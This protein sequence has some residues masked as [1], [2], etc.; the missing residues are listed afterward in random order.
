MGQVYQAT[1]TK[2]KRQVALKILP[3][4]FSADPERLARFQ[5]EAEV[6]ASLNHPNIAAIHGLEEAGDTR[7]LVLELVEGPTLADRIKQGPIPLDEALPIAK[8]IAEALE[9]AHEKGII[10]RDL[11][12]ANIKV[13]D[14]GTVKV[15]D[16]GLAKALDPSP[17]GDQSQSPTLTAM[18]TQMGVIMGTA[19]YM[20]PEQARGKTVDKRADIWAFGCVLYEMLTGR[21]AFDG[22]G[23]SEVLA[24]VIRDE[25]SLERIPSRLRRLLSRC[26]TKDPKQRLRDI[27]DMWGLVDEDETDTSGEANTVSRATWIG[28][29]VVVTLW[30]AYIGVDALLFRDPPPVAELTRFPIEGP[31]GAGVDGLSVSPDG[32]HIAF[33]ATN[34]DGE[35]QVWVRTLST[36][37]AR[38]LPGT[39]N[40]RR[41]V[42]FWSP[43]TRFIAFES[44]RRLRR[45]GLD[46]TPP[47]PIADLTAWAFGGSWSPTGAIVIGSPRG[48][49][50]IP[51]GGGDPTLI[52]RGTGSVIESHAAPW[53]L[54][55]GRHFV[56]L[57][58]SGD[59]ADRGLWIGAT[60]TASDEQ[61]AERLLANSSAAVFAPAT[62]DGGST[63][64][65]LF[66]R[67]GVLLA[68]PF[69]SD[70]LTLNGGVTPFESGITPG[71]EVVVG[72]RYGVSNNGLL[73][74][75]SGETPAG[76]A[77]LV[78]HDRTGTQAEQVGPNDSYGLVHVSPDGA[79]VTVHV[80]RRGGVSQALLGDL[81]R[82]FF[83]RLTQ[84]TQG[85]VV[86]I[87]AVTSRTAYVLTQATEVNPRDLFG[88]SVDATDPPTLW[89]SNE[90]QKHANDFSP[91]GRFLLYDEH[92]PRQQNLWVLPLGP[93]D[94]PAGDP[95]ALVATEA[96]ESHGQFSPD[97]RWIAYHSDDSGR[98]EVFVQAFTA[99][100]SPALTSRRVQI[101][102]GGGDKPR[103]SPA[104][105]ELYYRSPD[106]QLM[107]VPVSADTELAPGTPEPLFRL[108]RLAPSFFSCDVGAD[109]R[110]LINVVAI[111]QE[112]QA[113]LV[114]VLDW[115]T[116]L[117]Q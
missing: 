51:E 12:P 93:D 108:P 30:I 56:Y 19:A 112:E 39:E 4:A 100:P 38:P 41:S 36:L 22:E 74:F 84:G 60:D 64:Y 43:D 87:A 5:R 8:Q 18:A 73:V 95:V 28:W 57:R 69:D 32:R 92:A 65:L 82:N 6:L 110:F 103:W 26:L 72:L 116:L 86:E 70:T 17:T 1:D 11:K 68:Q 98:Y 34:A 76:T 23:I 45:V 101:S 53:F 96:D 24:K 102:S 75:R 88:G 49:L 115:E 15:L 67:E 14:D 29:A 52:T 109:G 16:F 78:W 55:D 80:R 44:G 61:P 54:P 37:E 106:G 107:A 71:D 91:D 81:S 77:R 20:S 113:P 89:V 58:V 46:G 117:D 105:D 99:D 9:A 63:G 3:E 94:A 21:Q 97:G 47:L 79:G 85:N 83:S 42:L 2:L 66:E 27:G 59:P 114:A 31:G 62:A 104:G 90:N 25:P 35:D 10:H 40:A 48:I 13:R 33:V 7:A 111:S 50:Q